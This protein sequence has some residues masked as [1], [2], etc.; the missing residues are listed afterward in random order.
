MD[1]V[2]TTFKNKT[3][4]YIFSL[5]Q[6]NQFPMELI[7]LIAQFYWET[8]NCIN[9]NLCCGPTHMI[10]YNQ[11]LL[12]TCGMYEY[13]GGTNAV[14]GN[15]YD[16]IKT[17]NIKS[18]VS[19]YH[20]H[21]IQANNQLYSCGVNYYGQLGLKHHIDIFDMPHVIPFNDV[22]IK[23]IKCGAR[24]TLVL[25]ETELYGCGDNSYGQLCLYHYKYNQLTKINNNIISIDCGDYHTMIQTTNGYYLCGLNTSGQ[26]SPRT[27]NYSEQLI[28]INHSN[29]FNVKCGSF[30]TIVDCADGVYIYSQQTIKK[31]NQPFNTIY[32]LDQD[33]IFLNFLK[34]N[35][36]IHIVG[37]RDYLII[38][39]KT[40]IHFLGA[41]PYL[42]QFK[43]LFDKQVLNQF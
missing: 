2:I 18:I 3:I 13:N 39:T 28:K 8:L 27:F 23:S 10:I 43:Y 16:L 5:C 6:L 29:I 35:D 17:F 9:V 22:L 34:I 7:H 19:G 11:N 26:I 30:C 21:I 41:S 14:L 4:F 1:I 36:I 25:T 38:I 15:Q 32:C 40:K 31:I 20:Y 24:H 12:R 42:K 33:L 37:H